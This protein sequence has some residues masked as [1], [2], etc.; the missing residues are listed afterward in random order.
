MF[1]QS[2]DFSGCKMMSDIKVIASKTVRWLILACAE[3][4]LAKF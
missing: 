1:A 4:L 2:Y 3:Q